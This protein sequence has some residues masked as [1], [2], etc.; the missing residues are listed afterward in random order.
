MARQRIRRDF[1]PIRERPIR[2]GVPSGPRG[3]PARAV[4]SHAVPGCPGDAP[5]P[6]SA[7]RLGTPSRRF[8]VAR[9]RHLHEGRRALVQL[10]A[11]VPVLDYDGERIEDSTQIAYLLEDRHP[12]P[13]LVP[14]DPYD[15][16]RMHEVTRRQ[17]AEK[18]RAGLTTA[19]HH[20]G[21][22]RYSRA[23][24]RSRRESRYNGTNSLRPTRSRR[25]APRR[26]VSR[27]TF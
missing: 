16:A 14:D 17:L 10:D 2:P 27:P 19:L 11:S 4:G 9:D 15:R 3:P 8:R 22:G 18:R 23:S 25:S 13:R 24:M 26:P 1:W 6:R 20:Q 12:E 5:R 21:F 7:A